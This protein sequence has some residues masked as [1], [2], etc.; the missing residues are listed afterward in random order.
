[1]FNTRRF[2]RRNVFQKSVTWMIIA[3]FFAQPIL[4]SAE[5]VADSNAAGKDRP[6]V[7]NTA[8][9]TTIV[10]ITA[11]SAAGVSRNQY[12]KF[13]VDT[14][15]LI[16]NNSTGI[17]Q[18]QLAGYVERNVSLGT[19]ARVILNEVTSTNPTSLL[20]YIEVAGQKADVIVAN[21]NG[22]SGNGFGFINTSRAVLTTGTPVF[23]GSGSLDAFRVTGGQIAIEGTGLNASD[24]DQ[25]D[26]ISRATTV[27][28][29]IWAKNL[30][31]IAGANQVDYSTLAV[32][33]ITGDTNAPQVA[34][35]VGA[36]GGMYAN[37]IFMVGTENGVG[38]K[39]EGILSATNGDLIVTSEGKVVLGN[40]TSANGNIQVT[41]KEGIKNTGTLYA[42]GNA[43]LF[44]QGDIDNQAVLAAGENVVLSGNTISSTGTLG[45]GIQSDGSLGTTGNL[46]MQAQN[47]LAVNGQNLVAGDLSMTAG[48]L[49]LKNSSTYVGGDAVWTALAG[50]INHTGSTTQVGGTLTATA[51]GTISNSKNAAGTAGDIVTG[52]L[53]LTAKNIDNTDGTIAATQTATVQA[54]S[55]T[56]TGGQLATNKDLNISAEKITGDGKLIAGQDLTLNVKQ[57]FTNQA[58]GVVQANNDLQITSD[59]AITNQGSLAAVGA[60][61]VKGTNITNDTN[62]TIAAQNVALQTTGDVTNAG[63]IDGSDI[64]V[65]AQKSVKNTGK[66]FGDTLTITADRLTNQGENGVL[67][68]NVRTDLLVS[69]T[70]GSTES[71]SIENKDGATIYSLG[72]IHI[73]ANTP[74]TQTG[75]YTNK[76]DS[77]LNQSATIEADGNI[78]I[79]ANNITNK[80][81]EFELQ[82]QTTTTTVSTDITPWSGYYKAKRNYTETSTQLV[83]VKDSDSGKIIAGKDMTL[84][85]DIENNVS[86]ITAGGTL[87][88]D[89]NSLTNIG[90]SNN[91]QVVRSGTDTQTRSERYC[92][93]SLWGKCIDH[94][95]RDVAVS[96]P[97][98]E[99]TSTNLEGYNA[100]ISANV[101]KGTGG[102]VENRTVTPTG[103]PVGSTVTTATKEFTFEVPESGL[104]TV[105][106][107]S[108]AKYLVETDSQFTNYKSFLSSDYLLAKLSTDPSNVQKRLGDGFYEQRLVQEQILKETGNSY[109]EGYTSSEEQ[110]KALMNNAVTEATQ[111]N[112]TVG[113]ALSAEQLASLKSDIVWM[114][115]KEVDGQKVLVPVVYLASTSTSEV[116][117]SGALISANAI[118]ITETGTVTNS[119]VI[120]AKDNASITAD[121]I[122][123]YGGTIESG[124]TTKL[125]ATQDIVNQSGSIVGNE[126]N[127]SAGGNVKN[128]TVVSTVSQGNVTTTLN[129][130]QAV[131]KATTGELTIQAGQDISNNGAVMKA[132][133]D[134]TLVAGGNVESSTVERT[135]HAAQQT[136]SSTYVRDSVTNQ[137]STIEGGGNVTIAAQKDVTLKGTEVTSGDNLTLVAGGNVSIEAAKDS[138][139]VD[140]SSTGKATY[141]RSMTDNETLVSSDLTAKN[142]VTVIATSSA[143]AKAGN[144]LIQGSNVTS[145]SGNITLDADKDVT[146]KEESVR[147]ETLTQSKD[148]TEGFLS[149]KETESLDH[150]IDNTVGSSTLSGEQVTVQSGKDITVQGSNVVATNDVALQAANNITVTTAQE[151]VEKESYYREKSSGISVSLSS[152][153]ASLFAGTTTNKTTSTE[154]DVEQ[155]GSVIGSTDGKVTL[156]A[157]KDASITGSQVTSKAG[158]TVT[159]ENVDINSAESTAALQQTTESTKSGLSISVGNSTINSIGKASD[160]VTHATEVNDTRLKNL[161]AYQAARNTKYTKYTVQ[162]TR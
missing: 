106:T 144:I 152:S 132:A 154:K 80:K 33:K 139:M 130:D 84:L 157:Q 105:H 156:E 112:L 44:A 37:K 94:D 29:G 92:S 99:N 133:G 46:I 91:L 34:I 150:T 108:T 90:Y 76:A 142:N 19:A 47:T 95:W 120:K 10:Q 43:E 117:T 42:Q 82:S 88:Y 32:Q 53:N 107:E 123:N 50:D 68:S 161:L 22:I 140:Y 2:N 56:N 155:V 20:G 64:Q 131:I 63:R 18:T 124:G 12:S 48:N 143:D 159:A 97:Y 83:V 13:N 14:S 11:P 51:Q 104:Y 149:K 148:K 67:A 101:I 71:A 59:S 66:V 151:T 41:A 102:K 73:A 1:M 23:G 162:N 28:A 147:K 62:G 100:I 160:E 60:M 75:Q 119:G 81:R 146:I 9:G 8:N 25:V 27:N 52:Q 79:S 153:G 136:G 4:V 16:L 38:V 30:N 87:S 40:S 103:S 31:V 15:G 70:A 113:V 3:I 96:A 110:Y 35:D 145:T 17:T 158:T 129:D 114:V 137:A 93:H 45:A 85:G 115:E 89:S 72:D 86:T 118:E 121:T 74:D 55:V 78:S 26:L 77:V 49:N 98:Y 111:L 36:L 61:S 69:G 109:L 127:L 125:N 39:S 5:T 116:T 21:P 135:E 57:D 128:E 141:R 126:V 6:V 58:S 24:A 65:T 54:D 134:V 122:T 7:E 138:S